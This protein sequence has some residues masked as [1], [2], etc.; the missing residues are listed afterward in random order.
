[1]VCF[2]HQTRASSRSFFHCV[3]PGALLGVHWKSHSRRVQDVG[4]LSHGSISVFP[5]LFWRPAPSCKWDLVGLP[6][7]LLGQGKLTE[8]CCAYSVKT[9]FWYLLRELTICA[10]GEKVL[11]KRWCVHSIS[12]IYSQFIFSDE[13]YVHNLDLPCWQISKLYFPTALKKCLEVQVIANNHIQ[14]FAI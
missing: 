13:S 11:K 6:F 1:M 14:Y 8:L 2:H 10:N 3:Y 12:K 7:Q 4:P 9:L 5:R